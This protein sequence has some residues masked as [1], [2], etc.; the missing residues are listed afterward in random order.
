[1]SYYNSLNLS[2]MNDVNDSS[3]SHQWESRPAQ[4]DQMMR[5]SDTVRGPANA[6]GGTAFGQSYHHHHG[7]H[8]PAGEC[9]PVKSSLPSTPAKTKRKRKAAQTPAESAQSAADGIPAKKRRMAP[10][11]RAAFLLDLEE[12]SYILPAGP[13]LQFT[14]VE[15]VALL[16]RWFGNT[17]IMTR[18]LNNKFN[19]LVHWA[20]IV[21]HRDLTL[22][23]Y[24]VDKARSG[25]SDQYRKAMRAADPL[26]KKALHQAPDDW[27]ADDMSMNQFVP[28]A[29]RVDG[30]VAPNPVPFKELAFDLKRLP[31]GYDAGDLTRALQFAMHNQKRGPNG[32]PTDFLFP[33]DIHVILGHI[34]YL[35]RMA[36]HTDGAA[37]Q[38]YDLAIS[39]KR[40]GQRITKDD[41]EGPNTTLPLSQTP[42]ARKKPAM[43]QEQKAS[44]YPQQQVSPEEAASRQNV[45]H[46]R[47]PQ[48]IPQ[49]QYADQRAAIAQ[50][51]ARQKWLP[52]TA[53]YSTAPPQDSAGILNFP[54]S[55][56]VDAT[57][58]PFDLQS[59][60]ASGSPARL[61][62]E[63]VDMRPTASTK[64]RVL[65]H[66]ARIV[67]Q[68]GAASGA[69]LEQTGKYQPAKSM[70]TPPYTPS[71][72]KISPPIFGGD[73]YSGYTSISQYAPSAQQ[74]TA[75]EME[76][77]LASHQDTDFN[78]LLT[79]PTQPSTDA[80]FDA[81]TA[82]IFGGHGT[83]ESF[84][85]VLMGPNTTH[86]SDMHYLVDCAEADNLED[87]SDLARAAR[88]CRDPVNF[89]QDYQVGHL[90]WIMDLIGVVENAGRVEKGG[91]DDGS[92]G[93]GY[94]V[95]DLER[96]G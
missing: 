5:V 23:D 35:N 50:N 82:A 6:Q 21:E 18:F 22:S 70:S 90:Q 89:A 92:L 88:Y 42:K 84:L 13:R 63:S 95:F 14:L 81:E 68:P 67:E 80:I 47:L 2:G 58:T 91:A 44:V 69:A 83:F 74:M 66:M 78:A 52:Q 25:F 65:E 31:Q 86:Y 56:S 7:M 53:L 46:K 72:N 24:E 62:S 10:V 79:P 61:E 41:N 93:S 51:S 34:G 20:M 38:R 15:I 37:I 32:E 1:M 73:G 75:E 39:T 54:G 45:S 77:M 12:H 43:A 19:S 4:I 28:D 49:Q 57:V 27:D 17:Q 64:K 60:T 85:D 76:A 94:E 9:A 11:R 8:N 29:A 96:L 36:E 40:V 16:P 59:P 3:R 55:S 48:E 33:D 71:C 87:K 26:W 30:Y